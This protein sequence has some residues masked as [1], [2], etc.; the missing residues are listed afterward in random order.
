M[1]VVHT[2]FSSEN[3]SAIFFFAGLSCLL[4]IFDRKDDN[5]NIKRNFL[6]LFFSGILLGFSYVVHFQSGIMI[7]GLGIWLLFHRKLAFSQLFMMMSG[8]CG[9]ALAGMFIDRW[10][11][12]RWFFTAWNY[13]RVNILENKTADFGVMPWWDYFRMIF[14]NLIPPFSII[15]IALIVIFFIRRPGHILTWICLPF[16]LVHIL[17]GHKEIRF[18]FPMITALPVMMGL[19]L[20]EENGQPWLRKL[21]GLFSSKA[22]R[23]LFRVFIASNVVLM[24]IASVKPSNENFP[25]YNFIYSHYHQK[26][27]NLYTSS[28]DPYEIGGVPVDFFKPEDLS[29]IVVK[30]NF[31]LDSLRPG[32]GEVNLFLVKGTNP[33]TPSF[34]ADKKPLYQNI[35]DWIQYFNFNN[36]LKRATVWR[37]YEMK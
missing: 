8:I 13:F 37:V 36:W 2:R 15:V 29:V 12:G 26:H 17:I 3:W 32:S 33:E 30:N 6:F 27:V 34:I 11:Y 31:V 10:F 35:P 21:T 1:P 25:F 16:F 20:D 18:L 24:F 23:I 28:R 5:E 22:T 7:A 19:A 14:I 9:A 4:Y